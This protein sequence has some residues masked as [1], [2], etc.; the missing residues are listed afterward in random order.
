MSWVDKSVNYID[1][2]YANQGFGFAEEGNAHYNSL[3]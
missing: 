1:L 2:E 3:Y